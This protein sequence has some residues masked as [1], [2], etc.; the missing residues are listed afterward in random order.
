MA[1]AGR[2]L[3]MT[4][5][6]LPALLRSDH[7]KRDAETIRDALRCDRPGCDCHRT[8]TNANV[9]CPAHD[10]PG[11]SLHVDFRDGKVLVRC[12]GGCAQERVIDA[13]RE[14]GLWPETIPQNG[15]APRPKLITKT[16]RYDARDLTGNVVAHHIRLDFTDGSKKVFWE[17]LSGLKTLAGLNPCDFLL[18]GS[19]EL[20]GA[21]EAVIVEGETCADALIAVG[22]AALGT[23]GA[24]V[25]PSDAVLRTL[26]TL[27]RIVLWPDNDRA[28]ITHM[29]RIAERLLALDFPPEQLW[30]ID[31]PY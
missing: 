25:L 15:A 29:Q 4:S 14:R 7:S 22:V 10:D 23:F 27:Q 30:T 20:H 1:T 19:E 18:Y 16:T 9:H 6:R 13:L 24:E 26:L 2:R 21:S 5:D 12:F 17:N 11:P 8:T 28:G 3:P 31:W